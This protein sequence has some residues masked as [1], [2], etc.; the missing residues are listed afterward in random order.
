M[1]IRLL[2]YYSG[3]SYEIIRIDTKQMDVLASAYDSDEPSSP[4]DDKESEDGAKINFEES[5]TLFEAIS[6]RCA[7]DIAPRVADKVP[8]TQSKH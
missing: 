3:Q 1:T 7:P 4:A 8:Y 2:S 5:S 6:K